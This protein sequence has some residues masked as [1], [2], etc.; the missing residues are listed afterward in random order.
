[1]QRAACYFIL[2][3]SHV[4]SPMPILTHIKMPPIS[5][6]SSSAAQ[7]AVDCVAESMMGGIGSAMLFLAMKL[8]GQRVVHGW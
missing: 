8:L 6:S 4:F 7:N 1:M 2:G 3:I 5:A